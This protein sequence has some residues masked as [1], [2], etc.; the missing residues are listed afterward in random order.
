MNLRT[1]V[2]LAK[3]VNRLMKYSRMRNITYNIENP[4]SDNCTTKKLPTM[5]N[6]AINNTSN[7]MKSNSN[8]KS[9][10]CDITYITLTVGIISAASMIGYNIAKAKYEKEE[11]SAL[12]L[13][14]VAKIVF[15]MSKLL[16][17]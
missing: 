4:N 1:G 6:L 17:G 7:C 8:V 16:R 12:S 15:S 3:E 9:L 13:K 2:N 14:D 10:N 5:K 11:A